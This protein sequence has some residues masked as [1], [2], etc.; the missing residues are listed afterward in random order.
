M[1]NLFHIHLLRSII[2]SILIAVSANE[3]Y[4]SPL[5]STYINLAKERFMSLDP[6]KLPDPPMPSYTFTIYHRDVF[7]KLNFKDYDSLLESRLARSHARESY[8][9]SVLDFEN[10]NDVKKGM[11]PP[12]DNPNDANATVKRQHDVQGS[13]MRELVPKTTGAYYSNGE[14]VAS[15]LLDSDEVRSFLVIDTGSDLVWWQCGPCEENKCYKQKFQNPLYNSTA[16]KTFRKVDCLRY[17][18]KY[19]FFEDSAFTCDLD[20]SECHY[21]MTYGSRQRTKGYMAD[22]VITFVLDQRPIR[23]MFGCGKD[24]TSGTN[25]S[26]WFSGIAGLGRRVRP[27]KKGGYSLPSQFGASLFSMCLPRFHSGK[28]STI[29]FHNSSYP[30]AKS[31]KLLPNRRYRSFFYVNLYKIFINDK[32]VL[33]NPSWWN[34]K[35]NMRGG[36]IVDTGTTFTPFPKDFYV[37]FRYAFRAEVRD[38]PMVNNPVGPFDTCYKDNPN[39]PG[40]VFPVVK[41]YFGSENPGTMLFLAQER[42]V[43]HFRGHYCLA[44]V[45]TDQDISI[46]GVNQLQGVAL[47]FDTSANSLSFDLDACD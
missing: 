44:F 37:I 43:V 29:S 33:V 39:G 28:G 45:G 47:T 25:F 8:L 2:F 31:A 1:E 34:F 40:L 14:Y 7:E 23:V 21:E 38:I 42:V 18:S 30:R 16:S 41:L 9:A 17:G 6:T 15:F 3:K 20:S 22:D 11:V 4:L 35:P 24:Q 46:L 26:D 5:N 13:K 19:C 27:Q 12:N 36:V 32:E 10:G